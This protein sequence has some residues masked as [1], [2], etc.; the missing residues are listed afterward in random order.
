MNCNS[1]EKETSKLSAANIYL[2]PGLRVGSR[3]MI[4]FETQLPELGAP[5]EELKVQDGPH[6]QRQ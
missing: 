1:V 6:Q 5:G 4:T 3:E 2:K